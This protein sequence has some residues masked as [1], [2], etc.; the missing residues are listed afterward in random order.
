MTK[1][2]NV[3]ENFAQ[4]CENFAQ[5]CKNFAQWC[6]NFA[7][8]AKLLLLFC[9]SSAPL[10]LLISF[11]FMIRNAKFDSNSSCLNRF[12]KFGINSLQK[13]QN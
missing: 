5:W 9:Y 8:G 1:V 13:L 6:K 7:Q 10:L 11:L 3:G 2:K 4:W 12:N